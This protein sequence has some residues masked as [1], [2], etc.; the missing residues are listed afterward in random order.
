VN[1]VCPGFVDTPMTAATIAN[2]VARTGR[3]SDQARSALEGK[4]PIG[5]LITPAEVA[6]AV[7]FCVASEAV[8]GQAINVDGGTVQ[9]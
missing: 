2:I 9:S 4:Q 1:A 6:G 7:W 8:T 3:T 5:R